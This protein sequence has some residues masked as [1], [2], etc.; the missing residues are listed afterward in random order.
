MRLLL[1]LPVWYWGQSSPTCSIH[2]ATFSCLHSI[3]CLSSSFSSSSASSLW[4]AT[5]WICMSC[6]HLWAD[7]FRNL[8]I[9]SRCLWMK[10]GSC[11]LRA[12]SFSVIS[13]KISLFPRSSAKTSIRSFVKEFYQTGIPYFAIPLLRLISSM[14]YTLCDCYTATY[15]EICRPN[16]RR[17]RTGHTNNHNPFL[18][19][20]FI[21]FYH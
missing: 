11:C 16:W 13:S 15:R 9:S 2:R 20:L 3:T 4:F 21:G 5:D 8:R 18:I 7:S 10:P 12:C 19:Y 14:T 6:S 17:S 1:S